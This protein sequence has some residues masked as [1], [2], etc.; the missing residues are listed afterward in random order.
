MTVLVAEES[1]TILSWFDAS[2]R[3][4]A[5]ETEPSVK[6]F[7]KNT[8]V[9]RIIEGCNGVSVMILFVAFVVAFSGNL[10]NTLWFIPF[11]V[12]VIHVLNVVRIAFLSAALFHYPEYEHLLH[13]V[14]FPLVIYGTVFFLWVIWVNTFSLYATKID[15]K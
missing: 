12:L 9:S 6:L 7:Y 10:K 4:E 8:Y 1:K 14:L 15:K 3:V 11:G 2:T 13:D 5:H